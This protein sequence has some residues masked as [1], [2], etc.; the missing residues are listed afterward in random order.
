MARLEAGIFS[1]PSGHNNGLVFGKG[2]TRNGKKTTVR[3]LVRPANPRTNAQTA[4]RNRFTAALQI[5]QAIGRSIYRFDWNNAV[6]DLPGYHS[7][8]SRLIDALSMN[9]SELSPVAE[10]T[11][12]ARHFPE[13]FTATA[14]TDEIEVSWS[15]ELGEVGAAN[16]EAVIIAVEADDQSGTFSRDVIVQETATREDEGTTI[17]ATGVAAGDYI[18]M[19]YFRSAE[20][21]QDQNDRRSAAVSL[22]IT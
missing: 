22:E 13:T 8:L 17:P 4:Q 6:G 16:D 15:A 20:P 1:S 2:R 7:F 11:L 18:V 21:V 5:L 3:E 12:G 10:T 19:L 9:G 14:G